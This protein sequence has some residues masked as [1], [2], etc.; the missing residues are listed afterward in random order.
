MRPTTRTV[1][2]ALLV[3]GMLVVA[4]CA[5]P[6]ATNNSTAVNGTI[7]TIQPEDT[8]ANDSA[9]AS[10]DVDAGGSDHSLVSYDAVG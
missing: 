8:P 1:L 5:G 7:T 10:A 4:G 3:I 2:A 9:G 6:S